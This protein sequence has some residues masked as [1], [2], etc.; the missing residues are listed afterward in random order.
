MKKKTIKNEAIFSGCGLQTGIKVQVTCKP[1]EADTGI[2]FRRIDLKNA[3]AVSINDAIFSR[4]YGRRSTISQ[5]KVEVQ[6]IEHFLAAL[7]A[8]EIDDITVE[9]NG[10]E[11]PALDGSAIGFIEN[12]KLAG[13]F[14]QSVERDLIVIQEEEAVKSSDASLTIYPAKEFSIS[15]SIDYKIESIERE[16]FEFK[17][18]L[19]SFEK[20]IA[21]ARTFCLKKEAELLLKLGF[22]KGANYKNTLVMDKNGP[23]G[24]SLRFK[25]EP[26]RHKVLDLV[27]DLY[28]LG[29]PI[30]G[31]IMA[32]RSGHRINAKMTKLLYDKYVK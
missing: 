8:L 26:V 3:P 28:M 15:Y 32:E 25:N 24:T 5:G 4:S 1:A 21:P 11:L 31:K 18:A 29:R 6:T 9:I 2:V 12:I 22:G 19:N 13:I 7:W 10:P 30:R 27:G 17:P 14:E 16:T 23:V 20:E